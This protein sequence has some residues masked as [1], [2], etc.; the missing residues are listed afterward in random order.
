[1]RKQNTFLD[2]IACAE[3][4]AQVRLLTS[5]S[6]RVCSQGLGSVRVWGW[7]R[8]G[9]WGLVQVS[10]KHAI[11]LA[12]CQRLVSGFRSGLGPIMQSEFNIRRQA[13]ESPRTFLSSMTYLSILLVCWVDV[14]GS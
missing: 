9:G 5:V 4:L 6:A 7:F 8:D 14:E 11:G 13:I 3:F 10:G 2:F 1:M 12:A